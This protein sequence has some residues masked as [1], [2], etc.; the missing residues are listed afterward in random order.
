MEYVAFCLACAWSFQGVLAVFQWCFQDFYT[1]FRTGTAPRLTLFG[2]YIR[3]QGTVGQPNVFA[4]FL[5]PIMLLNQSILSRAFNSRSKFLLCAQAAG[6]LGLVFSLSRGG[7]LAFIL[8][9]VILALVSGRNKTRR[10]MWASL[11]ILGL[12]VLVLWPFMHQR[13]VCD[14][15]GAALDRKYLNQ[16]AAEVIK[17]NFWLGVGIIT[18]TFAMYNYI[19]EGYEWNFI[20]RV[21]NLFLLVFAETGILGFVAIVLLF[22]FP[23]RDCLRL[24]KICDPDSQLYL[25]GILAGMVAMVVE[26]LVDF[27]W[28]GPGINSLYFLLLAIVSALSQ[29]SAGI[30]TD[31]ISEKEAGDTQT[32]RYG[33]ARA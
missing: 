1:V 12:I 25:N 29:T 13:I 2:D 20:Y 17:A 24:R 3:S 9:F 4:G 5:I 14:G 26:N 32:A 8:G 11:I 6:F 7:W 31:E 16:I 21:H 30:R 28:C 33:F 18:Y 23:V 19:P 22:V 10:R 15:G 27:V